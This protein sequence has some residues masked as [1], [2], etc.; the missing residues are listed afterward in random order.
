MPPASGVEEVKIISRK[1]KL[2]R[3]SQ[4]Y[5]RE[6]PGRP[7][8]SPEFLLTSP[9]HRF[10][11]IHPCFC[12]CALV[13]CSI[14]KRP[15]SE[16]K[17]SVTTRHRP[18]ESEKPRSPAATG[19]LPAWFHLAPARRVPV[20]CARPQRMA[21]M[22]QG[23]SPSFT[24]PSGCRVE[25]SCLS[26]PLRAPIRECKEQQKPTT[27]KNSTSSPAL[28][29]FVFGREVLRS[30]ARSIALGTRSVFRASGCG[31]AKTT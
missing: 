18:A 3:G 1:S 2:S 31:I 11:R 25:T 4:N 8:S 14:L 26:S 27:S 19:P 29:G 17:W 5:L 21:R 16:A 10:H 6:L 20:G 13:H 30:R 24:A 12:A 22:D 7:D 28:G 9:G 15:R 23:S